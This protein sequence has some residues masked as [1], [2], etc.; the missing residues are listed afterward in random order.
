VLFY[1]YIKVFSLAK[2]SLLHRFWVNFKSFL[3]KKKLRTF[4][5]YLTMAP[6]REKLK[7]TKI[8]FNDKNHV[9]HVNSGAF[10]GVAP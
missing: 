2:R 8:G 7:T 3:V 1:L 6:H 10:R 5:A 9:F 4:A